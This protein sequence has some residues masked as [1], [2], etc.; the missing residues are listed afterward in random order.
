MYVVVCVI[1]SF[2]MIDHDGSVVMSM[3]SVVGLV[4]AGPDSCGC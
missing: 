2:D 1:R 4:E 3:S